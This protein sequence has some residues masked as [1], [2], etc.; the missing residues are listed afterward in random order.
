MGFLK[1]LSLAIFDT[2][3]L[4]VKVAEDMLTLGGAA[5]GKSKP[6]TIEQLEQI[7]EDLEKIDE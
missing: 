1:G 3:M 4:P 5:Q 6:N 7:R 2:A